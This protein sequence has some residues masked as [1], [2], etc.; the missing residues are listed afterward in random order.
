M[1]LQR[2][3]VDG[4][5]MEGRGDEKRERR[6]KEKEKNW[7]IFSINDMIPSI[8]YVCF[9]RSVYKSKF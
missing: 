5:E 4:H 1:L 6:A 7:K 9:Y 3:M 8:F 2:S